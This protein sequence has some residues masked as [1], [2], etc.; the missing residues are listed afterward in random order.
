MGS[1]GAFINVNAGNFNFVEGGQHYFSIGEFNDVKVLVQKEGCIKAPEYSHTANRIYAI[2]QDGQLK[3]LTYYDEKHNQV[4]SIDLMH[5]HDGIKPHRHFNLNHTGPGIP[6]TKD[7][8]KLI[9]DI[10]RRFNL[11]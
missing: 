7:Q 8:E 9:Q 6:I 2:V 1:R 10:K 5:V 3:H 4:E 11:K